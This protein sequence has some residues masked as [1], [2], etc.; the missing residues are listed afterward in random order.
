MSAS[1]VKLDSSESWGPIP[2]SHASRAPAIR[3]VPRAPASRW[4]ETATAMRVSRAGI[5]KSVLRASMATIAS[6]ANAT[7]GELYRQMG[8]APASANAS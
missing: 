3:L 6:G 5:A 1:S 8:P 4:G 7:T 2:R